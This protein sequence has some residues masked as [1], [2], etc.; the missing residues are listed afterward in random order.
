MPAHIISHMLFYKYC[1]TCVYVDVT[2][3]FKIHAPLSRLCYIYIPV[4]PYDLFESLIRNNDD[5]LFEIG[6]YGICNNNY[7]V[8]V[9]HTHKEKVHTLSERICHSVY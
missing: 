8:D 9:H 6:L 3:K 2:A 1:Y 7:S 5:A 4:N